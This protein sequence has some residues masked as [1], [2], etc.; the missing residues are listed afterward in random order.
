[1][2]LLHNVFKAMLAG[3]FSVLGVA[4]VCVI[5]WHRIFIR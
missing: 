2:Q 4:Y 5:N 3:C 1:V